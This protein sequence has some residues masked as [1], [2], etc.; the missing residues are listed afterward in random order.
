M[1]K[2]KTQKVRPDLPPVPKHMRKLPVNEAGYPVPWFVSWIDGKPEF[3][4]VTAERIKEALSRKVCWICGNLLTADLAF[5]LGPMCAIN[6]TNSEPPNHVSCAIFAATAC[7]FLTRPQT[8]RRDEGLPAETS[9]PPGIA[10]ARNPGACAVWITRTFSL[11]DAG[12]GTLF[13]LGDPQRILWFAEGRQATRAE[14]LESIR[15]GLPLLQRVADEQGLDAR[16]ELARAH[17]DMLDLLP[18]E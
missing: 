9:D 16:R 13:K 17:H 10:L 4:C 6:R 2:Q 1:L 8:E 3:R 7:P 12:N 14:V 5:V 18:T 15:T 11:F